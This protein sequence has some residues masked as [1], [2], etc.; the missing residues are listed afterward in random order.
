MLTIASRVTSLLVHL[1]WVRFVLLFVVFQ[2]YSLGLSQKTTAGRNKHKY[3]PRLTSKCSPTSHLLEVFV[4]EDVSLGGV[5]GVGP[6][7]A[8]SLVIVI[9][10]EVVEELRDELDLPLRHFDLFHRAARF[11]Q[12]EQG[13]V[14]P[15]EERPAKYEKRESLGE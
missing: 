10:V 5:R 12:L 13:G 15:L 3:K 4:R 9:Q 8:V 11:L 14:Q 7:V 6:V 1:G 2:I